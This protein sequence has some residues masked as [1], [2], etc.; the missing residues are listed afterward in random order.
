M[1]VHD[2]AVLSPAYQMGADSE[3]RLCE[4]ERRRR[5]EIRNSKMVVVRITPFHDHEASDRV[6]GQISL[7]LYL[8]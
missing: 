3:S 8:I 7:R 2:R 4:T 1:V 6:L 5:G